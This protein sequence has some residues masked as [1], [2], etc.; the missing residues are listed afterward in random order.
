MRV[1]IAGGTGLIGRALTNVLVEK[2]HEVF[3]LT[4][5]KKE[6]EKHVQY[7]QWMTPESTP[8]KELTNIDALVNLAGESIGAKRWTK[9]RK[10]QILNSRI[11]ATRETIAL[12]KKLSPTP[13]VLINSSA[14]GYYG[15]SETETFTE[16][17]KPA[18]SNYL[19]EVCRVWEEEAKKAEDIGVRTVI[20]RTGLVLDSQ[21]GALPSILLPYRLFAGGTV[22]SG[23]QWVSWIHIDDA[24]RLLLFAIEKDIN[25]VINLT[26]PHPVTMKKFGKTVGK[27]LQRPHW[28]P[29][30][31]FA[32]QL[33]LGEMSTLLLDGK[34]VLPKQALEAGFSFKY[35][36]L[37]SAL[38]DLTK[39]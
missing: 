2:G 29:V 20:V 25:G 16:E 36:D 10:Q 30:P 15:D 17:S 13:P 27:V 3:I 38:Q 21:E 19:Q 4:R 14:I 39:P 8:E 11:D 9:E 18:N 12:L 26:A 6:N 24:A 28:F 33:L 22:G 35:Q 7:V 1:A 23:R 5:K 34:K 32:F 37:Y 31:S